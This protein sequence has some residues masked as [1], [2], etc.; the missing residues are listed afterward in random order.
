M[1]I[2]GM[3]IFDL[4]DDDLKTDMAIDLSLHRKKILKAK[5]LLVEFRDL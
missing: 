5:D 2:D 3:L 1:A 4:T